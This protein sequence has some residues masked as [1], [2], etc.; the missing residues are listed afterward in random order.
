MQRIDL[1]I[2]QVEAGY[3]QAIQDPVPQIVI[4][5]PT[6]KTNRKAQLLQMVG[7]V[8][9]RTADSLIIREDVDE[10]FAD[11]N[12]HGTSPAIRSVRATDRITISPVIRLA[13]TG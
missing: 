2:S 1:H 9:C 6:E 5:N 11:H 3:F 13:P 12:N 10:D 8:E 4:P 7:E